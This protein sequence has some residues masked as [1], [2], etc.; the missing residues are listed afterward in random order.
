MTDTHADYP[1]MVLAN[2]IFG[3]GMN[4]RLFQRV[5]NKE[6]LSYGVGAGFS[7]PAK[8]DDARFNASASCAPENA[9][10]VETVFKEELAKLLADGFTNDEVEAAKKSWL[11]SRNVSRAQDSEL[12][13]RLLS[14]RY[15]GRTLV[16]FDADLEAKV[17]ALSP[18]EL[19]AAMKK[20]LDVAKLNIVRAGDFKKAGVTWAAGVAGGTQ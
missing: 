20:H 1:A 16:G 19:Q 6:G 15:W 3:S 8:D 12:A 4:S 14:H 9:V 18:A 13:G 5:R 11:Q 10:K 7:A 17:A 2:Y